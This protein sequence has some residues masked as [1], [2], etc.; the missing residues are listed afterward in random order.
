MKVNGIS[1]R[2]AVK[3]AKTQQKPPSFTDVHVHGNT[4]VHVLYGGDLCGQPAVQGQQGWLC[5][6]HQAK[7]FR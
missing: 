4:C 3:T 1:N 5:E 7:V 6:Q 2:T